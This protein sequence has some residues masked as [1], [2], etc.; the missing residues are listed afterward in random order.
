MSK[1][2]AP[3]TDSQS[4]SCRN[5]TSSGGNPDTDSSTISED[6]F[7]TSDNWTSVAGQCGSDSDDRE[8]LGP[9]EDCEENQSV[10][11]EMGLDVLEEV[12]ALASELSGDSRRAYPSTIPSDLS[13]AEDSVEHNAQ[14][15]SHAEM[16]PWSSLASMFK[17]DAESPVGWMSRPYLR[18]RYKETHKAILKRIGSSGKSSNG[19]GENSRVIQLRNRPP[20]IHLHGILNTVVVAAATTALTALRMYGIELSLM[21]LYGLLLVFALVLAIVRVLFG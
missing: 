4:N 1:A 12:G 16:D 8:D 3:K 13:V 7:K 20:L 18:H 6:N 5:E 11:A 2:V 10:Y 17:D 14:G 15:H 21:I 9:Y 19:N